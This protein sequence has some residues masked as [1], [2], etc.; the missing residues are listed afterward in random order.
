MDRR[1]D[2]YLELVLGALERVARF[3]GSLP[4]QT[5]L[6]DELVQSAVERQLEIAGDALA[7]LRR[8]FPDIF[9]RIPDGPLIIAFRNIL[10]HGYATLDA[11]KV[12][13]AAAAR[14]PELAKAVRAL[15]AEFP[16]P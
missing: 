10:A 7:Q 2:V 11:R 16:E 5:Y 3:L 13:E 14:A 8:H 15:L 6:A 9:A 4:V 12:H 1:P